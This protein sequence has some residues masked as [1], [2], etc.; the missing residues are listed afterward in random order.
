MTVILEFALGHKE[1]PERAG[2]ASFQWRR[3]SYEN[4]CGAVTAF[5]VLPGPVPLKSLLC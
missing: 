4:G 1:L 2:A 3:A 5:S